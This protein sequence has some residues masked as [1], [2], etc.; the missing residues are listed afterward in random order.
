MQDANKMKKELN[1]AEKPLPVKPRKSYG[2]TKEKAR[3][4]SD[5]TQAAYLKRFPVQAD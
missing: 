5:K 1:T 2:L 3:R 4:I